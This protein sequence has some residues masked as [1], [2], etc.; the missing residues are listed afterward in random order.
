[1]VA[2]KGLDMDQLARTA[3][4]RASESWQRVVSCYGVIV[5]KTPLRASSSMRVAHVTS[6]LGR[7]AGGCRHAS[8]HIWRVLRVATTLKGRSRATGK[9]GFYFVQIKHRGWISTVCVF[10]LP[11]QIHWFSKGWLKIITSPLPPPVLNFYSASRSYTT[12]TSQNVTITWYR[13][14]RSKVYSSHTLLT[15]LTPLNQER[16]SSAT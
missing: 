9:R 2:W 13:L 16:W 15:F 4:P 5:S 10:V 11:A 8:G 14:S 7:G 6:V 12:P 1:M 3:T